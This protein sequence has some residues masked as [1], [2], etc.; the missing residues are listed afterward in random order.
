MKKTTATAAVS[1]V[2]ATALA[3]TACG[4]DAERT[5]SGVF[6]EVKSSKAVKAVYKPA[7]RTV[8]DYRNSCQT[9]TRT[10][11]VNGKPRTETYQDCTK[12]QVGTH[13][14]S[15]RKLVKPGKSA[16]Y[17]VELDNVKQDGKNR[18]DVTFEVSHSTYL[19]YAS[20][21][22]GASVKKLSY[23]REVSTCKR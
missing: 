7:T 16:I 1:G 21:N 22:E 5:V 15:Y 14:E 10:K 20:K 19:K 4:S 2:I 11:T 12:V 17:C 18:D 8:V 23:K 3:L 6:D 13:Q 9:K